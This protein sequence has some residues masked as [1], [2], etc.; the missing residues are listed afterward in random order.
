MLGEDFDFVG[1]SSVTFEP[2]DFSTW[3]APSP[4]CVTVSLLNDNAIE[5]D[6][7]FELFI[8]SNL[9]EP[10]ISP[11]NMSVLPI[12]IEDETG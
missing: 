11:G 7:D 1:S 10:E 3:P 6:H 2:E 4:A 5:G 9:S 12:S 8:A